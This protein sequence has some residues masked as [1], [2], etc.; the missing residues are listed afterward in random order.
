MPVKG[1]GVTFECIECEYT[2]SLVVMGIRLVF[3]VGGL[4][5]IEGDSGSVV[6]GN[7]DTSI[8]EIEKVVVI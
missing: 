8:V 4:F 1:V 2:D 3:V 5:Y 7:Q 6:V